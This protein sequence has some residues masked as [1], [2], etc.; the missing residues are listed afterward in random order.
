MKNHYLC[1]GVPCCPLVCPLLAV[2]GVPVVGVLRLPEPVWPEAPV[3]VFLV[4]PLL[5]VPLLAVPL[6][7]WVLVLPAPTPGVST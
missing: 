7:A 3:D 6:L 2:P 1:P 5:V 4:V